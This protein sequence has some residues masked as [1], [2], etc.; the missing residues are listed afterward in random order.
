MNNFALITQVTS[1]P[2]SL[3]K[4]DISFSNMQA[5]ATNSS[6]SAKSVSFAIAA[7]EN[8]CTEDKRSNRRRIRK[9]EK[10]TTKV[11]RRAG[12]ELCR[13]KILKEK[14]PRIIWREISGIDEQKNA[15]PVDGAVN[16]QQEATRCEINDATSAPVYLQI[17]ED[18]KKANDEINVTDSTKT[19][20]QPA[21][22]VKSCVINK[23]I[24][25]LNDE[26]I[27]QAYS[28][29]NGRTTRSVESDDKRKITRPTSAVIQRYIE[30]TKQKKTKSS[31]K[32]AS[33]LTKRPMSSN[34]VAVNGRKRL[35][36]KTRPV[37]ANVLKF[38]YP[39]SSSVKSKVVSSQVFG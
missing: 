19:K 15:T 30:D 39:A 4:K 11:L 31:D 17:Q 14:E 6:K 12:K 35:H 37:S 24:T 25:D 2:P 18:D 1:K 9:T 7:T 36:T 5:V 16:T 28:D 23:S 22:D 38:S 33:N 27:Q 20:D 26:E 32:K 29:K 21:T 3:P 10:S 13:R 8:G 34:P